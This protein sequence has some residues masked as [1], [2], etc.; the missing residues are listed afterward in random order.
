VA[1]MTLEPFVWPQTIQALRQTHQQLGV[2][3]TAG[4]LWSQELHNICTWFANCR[5]ELI[6]R[7]F[8]VPPRRYH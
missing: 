5:W 1:H 3:H 8:W 2:E 6:F 7:L 4:T